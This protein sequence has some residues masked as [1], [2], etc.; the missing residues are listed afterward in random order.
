MNAQGV[1]RTAMLKCLSF[2]FQG[3]AADE[4]RSSFRKDVKN[5][6]FRNASRVLKALDKRLETSDYFSFIKEPWNTLALAEVRDEGE[7]VQ[8]SFAG[9]VRRAKKLQQKLG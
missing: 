6:Q 8:T 3:D 2:V 7:S 9:L 5:G 4:Y 1:S